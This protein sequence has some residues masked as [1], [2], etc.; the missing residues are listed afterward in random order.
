M[1]EVIKHITIYVAR[2]VEGIAALVIAIAVLQAIISYLANFTSS[3]VKKSNLQ[4]RLQFGSSAAVALEFLLGADI[5]STAVAP[6]W[7]EI[8]KLAAIAVIRT[9]L[10]Y[11]LERDLSRTG[12]N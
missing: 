8:G 7:D 9:G 4:I 6:S 2:G 3:T 12:E 11:F 10:N 5:L 1:D